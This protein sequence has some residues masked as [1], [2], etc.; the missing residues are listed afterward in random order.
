MTAGKVGLVLSSVQE[1]MEEDLRR[2][3][4]QRLDNQRQAG[5]EKD[6]QEGQ[7]VR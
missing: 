1:S 5:M 7:G 6:N 4:E 3:G 2:S